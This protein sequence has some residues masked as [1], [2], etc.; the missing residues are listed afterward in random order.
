MLLLLTNGSRYRGGGAEG[1]FVR[2]FIR[3]F[4]KT[5]IVEE[6]VALE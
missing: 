6:M 4:T 3:V 5:L 1:D 2:L